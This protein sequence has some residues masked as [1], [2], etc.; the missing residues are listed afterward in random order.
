MFRF[1]RE[2]CNVCINPGAYS[3]YQDVALP[4]NVVSHYKYI[5]R[6]FPNHV[7]TFDDNKYHKKLPL[8]RFRHG[9][10]RQ[11]GNSILPVTLTFHN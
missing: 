9:H 7:F 2:L 8:W 5:S 11:E 4:L 10:M 1:G 6:R 3:A